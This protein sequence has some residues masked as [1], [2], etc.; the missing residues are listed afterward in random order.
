[1]GVLW[2]DEA[3]EPDSDIGDRLRAAKPP[4]F[5]TKPLRPTQPPALCGTR[6]EYRPKCSDALQLGV[7]AGWLFR[8]SISEEVQ[9]GDIVTTDCYNGLP[10]RVFSVR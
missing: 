7:K 6:N 1:M 8:G 3:T 9:D 4:R 5:F 2:A 10:S